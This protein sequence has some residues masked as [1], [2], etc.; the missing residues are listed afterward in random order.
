MLQYLKQYVNDEICCCIHRCHWLSSDGLGVQRVRWQYRNYTD[1]GLYSQCLFHWG[2][3]I[4]CWLKNKK[5]K[6]NHTHIVNTHT[7][8]LKLINFLAYFSLSKWY[9]R[10]WFKEQR[11]IESGCEKS[12]KSSINHWE[13]SA[14]K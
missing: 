2:E 8:K 4:W 5:V 11:N 9:I 6:K 14:S 1:S 3:I 13:C 7:H 12:G 10:D